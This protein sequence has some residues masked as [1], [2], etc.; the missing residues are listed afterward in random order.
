MTD[1]VGSA[2]YITKCVSL[3]RMQ[4]GGR[5]GTQGPSTGPVL[6]PAPAPW[7]QAGLPASCPPQ[8]EGPCWFED[9]AEPR[10]SPQQVSGAARLESS[11][12][13]SP[14]PFEAGKSV[15]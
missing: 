1:L 15:Y 12:P 8:R 5:T 6:H 13:G 10:A 9:L 2:L 4:G 3:L 14:R 11:H 7:P